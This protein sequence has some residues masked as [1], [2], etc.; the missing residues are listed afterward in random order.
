MRTLREEVDMNVARASFPPT[1]SSHE[2]TK[3]RQVWAQERLEFSCSRSS[4]RP[5]PPRRN[6]CEFGG[7]VGNP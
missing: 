2:R 3:R 5:L 6:L 7:S 4:A 1:G